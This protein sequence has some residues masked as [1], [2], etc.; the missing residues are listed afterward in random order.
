MKY[1]FMLGSDATI[2]TDFVNSG[3]SATVSHSWDR[4]DGD[5]ES[6]FVY[7]KAIDIRGKSSELSNPLR[8][9]VTNSAITPTVTNGIGATSITANSVR[10]NGEITDTGGEHPT[11]II[12]WGSIDGGM[13]AGSSAY[14]SDEG[15]L[16]KQTFSVDVSDLAP[17]TPYYFRCYASNSA[18]S[19]WASSTAT[20]TTLNGAKTEQIGAF[21]NGP[22]YLDYNGNRVWDPA[23]GDVSFWFGTSGD[24]PLAGDWNGDGKDEIGVFRNGPWYLD[25]N[26]N[27]VWDPASGDVSFWFGTSGDLPL[28]GD[29]NGDG[30]DEIGDISAMVRGTWTIMATEFGILLRAMCHSGLERV[31]TCL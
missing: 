18:G 9:E 1:N 10:L 14:H 4:F 26:G 22:W 17:G 8:V 20:F 28:A 21:R 3:T 24:L 25:Y 12:Y 19:S 5:H 2:T 15:S 13:N 16:G 27:R 31:A 11:V 7:A 23:S 29:W 30:K 6:A